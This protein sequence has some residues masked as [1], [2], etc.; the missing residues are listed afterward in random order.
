MGRW[1]GDNDGMDATPTTPSRTRRALF[2]LS[3]LRWVAIIEATSFLLLLVAT[4]VKYGRDRPEGV[5]VLGPIHGGLFII[6]IGMAFL[7]WRE[8][9]WKPLIFL[10]I[11]AGSVIPLGGYWVERRYLTPAR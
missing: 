9:R 11:L 8:E 5:E 10:T 3:W 7:L 4:A 2:P 1:T 6:Y